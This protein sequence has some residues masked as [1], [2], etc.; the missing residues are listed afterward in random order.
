MN[1]DLKR[2][3][4]FNLIL[5]WFFVVLFTSTAFINGGAAYGLKALIAT[6]I[7]GV[8]ASI[9]YFLPIKDIVKGIALVCIPTIGAFGLSISA[10]GVD[11]MFNIY[12]LGLVMAAL[13]FRFKAMVIYG[14]F[15]SSVIIFIYMISP[16]SLLGADKAT[17]GEFVPRM[18]AYL[19]IFIVLV[20]LTK[21]G[22]DILNKAVQETERSQNALGQLDTIFHNINQTVDQ[23]GNQLEQCDERMKLSEES[24]E[25]ISASMREVALSVESSAGKISN[26][27]KAAQKSR[28]DVQKT[29]EVMTDIENRFKTVLVDV[30]HSEESIDT[31]KIQVDKIKDAVDSSHSTVKELSDRM[32]D[33]TNLL[34][35][36]TSISEQTN[37][38]ALNASIE[39]ARA[40]EHGR[41]F[42]VVADE[43]RKLSEESGKFAN[44]IRDI[45]SK[46]S[47]STEQ[48]IEEV[49]KGKVAMNSGY[50]TMAELHNKFEH[51]KENFDEVSTQI[52]LEYKLVQSV[53]EQFKVIDIEITEIAAFI[54]EF[55]ATSEE[56]SAQTE[57][58]VAL[59]QEVVSYLE[60][61]VKMGETLKQMTL[62]S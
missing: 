35:G 37:L 41:G 32:Q 14:S 21:W 43:I 52:D 4:K 61:V 20:F 45:T 46:L 29:A 36:I 31:M 27:S 25:G 53:S 49:E 55:S 10:G 23:L 6:G 44:G 54:E 3:I 33:I 18:G 7:T 17:L 8:L 48:A 57:M 30:D 50:E 5:T 22:N 47:H 15:W 51:M 12:I 16:A 34:Q 9:L 24:S 2:A 60:S 38:L 11:R 26:V 40:G 28:Q 1:Y 19:S 56:V 58:Q 62:K 59:S 42:A 39:A 13:Y